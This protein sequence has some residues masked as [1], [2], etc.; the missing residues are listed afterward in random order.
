ML[1][2]IPPAL[3]KNLEILFFSVMAKIFFPKSLLI[4]F[5]KATR[6]TLNHKIRN[7]TGSKMHF[8]LLYIEHTTEY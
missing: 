8:F 2:D 7:S 3:Q 1:S 4:H 5:I 6:S